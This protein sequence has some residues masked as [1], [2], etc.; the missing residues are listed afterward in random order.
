MKVLEEAIAAFDKALAGFDKLPTAIHE[1]FIS[2]VQAVMRIKRIYEIEKVRPG[3]QKKLPDLPPPKKNPL[4]SIET[5]QTES[6]GNF[7]PRCYSIRL[8]HKG[9]GC[10][11]CQDCSFEFGCG[12]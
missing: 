11:K 4:F 2:L 12:G 6:T 9:G 7:C 10:V 3:P 8:H 1:G 5:H